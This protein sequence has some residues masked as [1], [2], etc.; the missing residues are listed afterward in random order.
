MFS[1][2]V[3]ALSFEAI[4]QD[5]GTART[6]LGPLRTAAHAA[7]SRHHCRRASLSRRGDTAALAAIL[8]AAED[9]FPALKTL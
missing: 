9:P 4:L 5:L 3:P 6:R 1:F 8:A 2:P 7:A